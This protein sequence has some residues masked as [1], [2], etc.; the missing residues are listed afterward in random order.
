MQVCLKVVSPRMRYVKCYV[1]SDK[2]HVKCDKNVTSE[3]AVII[4][5]ET[6]PGVC[7]IC[8]HCRSRAQ[9]DMIVADTSE[10][11]IELRMASLEL[12]FQRMEVM[13][14]SL[15]SKPVRA[16]LESECG[17][18]RSTL[19]QIQDKCGARQAEN[20]EN[21]I[22]NTKQSVATS[23]MGTTEFEST[24]ERTDVSGME[25]PSLGSKSVENVNEFSPKNTRHHIYSKSNSNTHTI[26]A[27]H[28][29][30]LTCTN[31][32]ESGATLFDAKRKHDLHCWYELCA[33]MAL[34][35]IKPASVTRLS[36][37][38]SS[39]H[40]GQP[41]LLRVT[42]QGEADV[43]SAL[44][45]SYLINTSPDIACRIYADIPWW[46]RKTNNYLNKTNLRTL[47]LLGIPEDVVTAAAHERIEH[48][49]KQWRYIADTLGTQ[50]A[51]VVNTFRVP[52]SQNYKGDGPNPLKITFLTSD[53]AEAFKTD[54]KTNRKK[55]PGDVRLSLPKSDPVNQRHDLSM[56]LRLDSSVQNKENETVTKNG[57]GPTHMESDQ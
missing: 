2:I 31:V 56:K 4:N 13:M 25:R 32:S 36:R 48:D 24:M 6:F 45:H 1:C 49:Y 12:G 3:A 46:E 37:R 52:R 21:S 15:T 51:V 23:E 17:V 53:M 40:R 54:W 41:R 10:S 30:S 22:I 33:Q 38:P 27:A 42:L 7:Y 20:S 29:L 34:D 55:L 9:T 26:K 5:S 19:P 8:D 16:E 35:P 39:P 44:L 47:T 18:N 14:T 50:N 28:T 43:E 57:N 11:K